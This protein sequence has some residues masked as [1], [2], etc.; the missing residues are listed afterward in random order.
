[1]PVIGTVVYDNPETAGFL[2]IKREKRAALSATIT[3]IRTDLLFN[4]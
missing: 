2:L 4:Q 3:L 1:V